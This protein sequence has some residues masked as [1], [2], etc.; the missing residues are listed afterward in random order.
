[1]DNATKRQLKKQDQFLTLTNESIGWASQH[2]QKAIVGGAIAV[3]A[4]LAIVGGYTLL[5]NRSAAA[6]AAFGEAMQTYQTPLVNAAQPVP[7]GMKSFPD[8]TSRAVAAMAQFQQVAS[9]Y[10]LTKGG[11][12]AEYFVGL[13]AMEANQPGPAEAALKK[14]AAVW[15]DADLAAAAKLALAGLYQQTGRD[16]QA[17]DLYN[18]LAKGH[19]D[20]V[21]PFLAQIQLAELYQSEG[22]TE[23]ARKLYAEVKDKDKDAKGKPGA[24]GQIAADK[25][26]PAPAGGAG[27]ALGAQ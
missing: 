18:Q 14:T 6:E 20:T 3:A 25:L 23:Q 8:S 9:R 11:K 19:S 24:A 15:G 16:A 1:V 22:K 26:N 21:S 13:T 4:I 7:P 10:G 5:A 27:G 2:R 12:L 17:V